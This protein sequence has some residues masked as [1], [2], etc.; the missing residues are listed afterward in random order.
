MHTKLTKVH[1]E[2]SIFFMKRRV[3]KYTDMHYYTNSKFYQYKKLLQ[4][5]FKIQN[6]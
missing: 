2:N 1:N 4:T 5:K 6:E 3:R